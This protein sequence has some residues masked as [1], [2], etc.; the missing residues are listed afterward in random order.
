MECVVGFGELAVAAVPF[1]SVGA[2]VRGQAVGEARK[3]EEAH[4]TKR[5]NRILVV[6][7][8]ATVKQGLWN[9]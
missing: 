9:E 8:V 4:E 1:V 6:E 2:V 5:R 7:R 3:R